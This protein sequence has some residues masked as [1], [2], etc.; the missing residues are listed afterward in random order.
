[1]KK[2]HSVVLAAAALMPLSACGDSTAKTKLDEAGSKI[3]SAFQDLTDYAVDRKD[4][5]ASA[6]REKL[7]KLDARTESAS[8]SM[9]EELREKREQLNDAIEDAKE[10]SSDNWQS[11]KQK[12][13]DGLNWMERK[14]RG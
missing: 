4:A 14:L 2:L 7:E 11:A 1:M 9:K 6:A 5:F 10:A 3:S 8:E 12:V 13:I